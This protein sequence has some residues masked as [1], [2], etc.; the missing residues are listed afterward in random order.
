[1]NNICIFEHHHL[2]LY[3]ITYHSN[4]QTKAD[5]RGDICTKSIYIYKYICACCFKS[6]DSKVNKDK[7]Y[8]MNFSL[9][10]PSDVLCCCSYALLYLP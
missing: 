9:Q 5:R 6:C 1:M 7:E 4:T 10:I 8:L 2:S 3:N